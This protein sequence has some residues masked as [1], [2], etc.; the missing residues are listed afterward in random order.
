MWS[1]AR[2]GFLSK[3]CNDSPSIPVGDTAQTCANGIM[4]DAQTTGCGLA[5]AVY[6]SYQT[7]GPVTALSPDT[8]RNES[9]NCFT[10]GSGTTGYVFCQ[11]QG[12]TGAVYMRWHP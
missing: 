3:R 5:Q 10:G 11:G 4:I 2:A 6:A 9:L 12:A 7:D 1:L 8:G